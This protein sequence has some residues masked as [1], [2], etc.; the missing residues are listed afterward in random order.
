MNIYILLC[1]V[2]LLYIIIFLA[3]NLS[4]LWLMYLSLV[5]IF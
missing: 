4:H 2:L 1:Q 5:G 3:N